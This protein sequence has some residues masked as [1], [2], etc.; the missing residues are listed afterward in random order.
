M[1][2]LLTSMDHGNEVVT[3]TVGP[4]D[5]TARTF[6]IHKN[7]IS[8]HSDYFRKAFTSSYREG[9]DGHLNVPEDWLESFE[10][11][12][13]WLYSGQ[14]RRLLHKGAY[15]ASSLLGISVPHG[16]SPAHRTSPVNRFRLP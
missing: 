11:L 4:E 10:V 15:F 5:G 2:A 13:E 12:Y 7:L 1:I 14:S 3:V 8:M 9:N 6:A 16:T